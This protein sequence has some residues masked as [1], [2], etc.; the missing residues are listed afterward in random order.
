MSLISIAEGL[1]LL[2]IPFQ[3]LYTSVFFVEGKDGLAIVDCATTS[4]DVDRYILPALKSMKK[5]ATHL[6]LTHSHGDHAG[7]APRLLEQCPDLVCLAYEDVA[8]PRFRR[9][10]AR[11]IILDRLQVIPILGH[12]NHSVGYLDRSTN[13]LISG[14]CLQLAGV[15]KYTNGIR[16]PDL[17]LQSLETLKGM[18]IERIVA[19]H[20]Y[21]PL[22]NLAE[23]KEAV[24]RY[25]DTCATICR[26][27]YAR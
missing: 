13:T 23:G 22:G 9:L 7:G 11:E 1:F 15:G 17:Y 5:S 4:D 19:S 3:E 2:K 12:T 18:E 27:Q 20:D 25:L 10:T 8:L 14:D 26:T 21:V 16:Y 6:L 24:A